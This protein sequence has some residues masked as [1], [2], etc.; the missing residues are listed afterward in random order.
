M[1]ISLQLRMVA[2]T[3][4]LHLRKYTKHYSDECFLLRSCSQ[5]DVYVLQLLVLLV[6][7]GGGV[8]MA[9]IIGLF[10]YH[11]FILST[12]LSFFL[13]SFL[14]SFFHFIHSLLHSSFFPFSLYFLFPLFSLSSILSLDLPSSVHPLCSCFSPFSLSGGGGSVNSLPTSK[15]RRSKPILR[16]SNYTRLQI[17]RS[18]DKGL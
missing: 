2:T 12:F 15:I 1:R 18:S 17:N 11:V 5:G 3:A 14:L 13:S 16:H 6:R 8:G 10:Y 4:Q 7:G 9:V